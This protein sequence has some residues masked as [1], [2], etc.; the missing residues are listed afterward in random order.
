MDI[1]ST[2]NM[3][4]F[5]KQTIQEAGAIAKGYFDNGV[6]HIKT[7]STIGD[8]VTE[9]DVAVSDFIVNKIKE[10]YPEE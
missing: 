6:T 7:K 8:L 5:L 4:E 2:K 9:A 1:H 3:Q 10:A